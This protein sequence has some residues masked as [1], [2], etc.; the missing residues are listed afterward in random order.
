MGMSFASAAV[1]AYFTTPIDIVKI[2]LQLADHSKSAL[3]IA[4]SLL[5]QHGPLFFIKGKAPFLCSYAIL[6]AF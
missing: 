3:G 5:K 1:A 2:N 4:A 6:K